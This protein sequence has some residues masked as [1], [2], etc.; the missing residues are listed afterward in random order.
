MG[1]K[2]TVRLVVTYIEDH[3]FEDMEIEKIAKELNYSKFYIAR[4][5][6]EYTGST[7]YKYIQRRRLTEAARMLV[8]TDMSIVDI[9]Y[10]INYHSQQAFTQAFHQV[11]LCTPQIYRKNQKFSPKQPRL[12][13]WK[14]SIGLQKFNIWKG[15]IAV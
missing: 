9:A 4:I 15:G 13:M 2:S 10:E 3:L 1:Q 7:I 14:T 8:E 6:R 5:F 11:Y 12:M